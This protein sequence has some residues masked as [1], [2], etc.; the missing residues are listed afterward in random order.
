MKLAVVIALASSLSEIWLA[1]IPPTTP[2]RSNKVERFPD[3]VTNKYL[4]PI[5]AISNQNQK[6]LVKINRVNN[7]MNS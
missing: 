7:L 2:P 6:K 4:P 5:A 3:D 1:I